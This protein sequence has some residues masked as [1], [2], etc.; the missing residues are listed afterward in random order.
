MA[1]Y[2]D[3][4]EAITDFLSSKLTEDSDP[5]EV[6]RAIDALIR[7]GHSYGTIRRVLDKLSFDTDEFP[8]E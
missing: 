7:K 5:K 4:S 3:Q 1:D 2:P 8:E 6:R